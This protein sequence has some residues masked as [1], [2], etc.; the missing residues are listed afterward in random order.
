[1]IGH[2]LAEQEEHLHRSV[3]RTTGLNLRGPPD[4]NEDS[5][6]S[7]TPW[8]CRLHDLFFGPLVVVAVSV[9]LLFREPRHEL[10]PPTNPVQVASKVV[11]RIALL[12]SLRRIDE[13]V[14]LTRASRLI[15]FH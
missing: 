9:R 6:G 15:L 2:D 3:S 13:F 4:L 12:C 8:P 1:M 10:Q 5:D 11:V 14:K 7:R